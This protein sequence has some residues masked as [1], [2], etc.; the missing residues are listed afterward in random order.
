ML[1]P[2][3]CHKPAFQIDGPVMQTAQMGVPTVVVATKQSYHS[4][5]HEE[6]KHQRKRK[7]RFVFDDESELSDDA[8][9]EEECTTEFATLL[10]G[11]AEAY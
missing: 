6:K 5:H 2:H 4:R 1:I 10:G 7:F 11:L 3:E 9:Q 8:Y